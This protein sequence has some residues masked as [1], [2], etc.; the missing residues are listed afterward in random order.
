M[1]RAEIFIAQKK[2]DEAAK[3]VQR[4]AEID[5]KATETIRS[6]SLIEVAKSLDLNRPD[7][8]RDPRFMA[9]W[10]DLVLIHMRQKNVAEVSRCAQRMMAIDPLEARFRLGLLSAELKRFDEAIDW[11][12]QTLAIKNNLP[13]VYFARGGAY[14]EKGDLNRARDDFEQVVRL[15]PQ[16][17]GAREKLRS[18]QARLANPQK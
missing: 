5:P 16:D 18:I 13:Q 14:E 10:M 12:T 11:Y 4:L 8:A 9:A 2:L 3:C 15:L 6:R 17:P 7:E 1:S